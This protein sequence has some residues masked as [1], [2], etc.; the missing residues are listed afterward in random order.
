MEWGNWVVSKGESGK[1]SDGLKPE[2]IKDRPGVWLWGV[3]RRPGRGS[4]LEEGGRLEKCVQLYAPTGTP[5]FSLR[6]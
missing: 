1:G 6:S 5:P 2:K 3:L 4:I